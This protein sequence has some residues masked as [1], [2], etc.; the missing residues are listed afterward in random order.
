MED[1]Q[2]YDKSIKRKVLRQKNTS[3]NIDLNFVPETKKSLK[4]SLQVIESCIHL[5]PLSSI[6]ISFNGGKDACVVFYLVYYALWKHEQQ[7]Q[8]TKLSDGNVINKIRVIYFTNDDIFPELADFIRCMIDRYSLSVI[9]YDCSFKEGMQRAVDDG[10]QAVF[11]GVRRGDPYMDEAEHYEPS[12]VGWP[13]FMRINPIIQWKYKQVWEFLRTAD[14]PYCSLYDQGYSSL[15]HASNTVRNPALL[16]MHSND[17]NG[18]DVYLPAYMLVDESL[19]RS[20]RIDVNA[21]VTDN[22]THTNTVQTS[23]PTAATITSPVTVTGMRTVSVSIVIVTD[24]PITHDT[25][26]SQSLSQSQSSIALTQRI[27]KY[28]TTDI[29]L[30]IQLQISI[31]SVLILYEQTQS[32]LPSS[33]VLEHCSHL[34]SITSTSTPSS[35]RTTTT[36]TSGDFDCVLLFTVTPP[37]DIHTDT[38][39]G[40]DGILPNGT[41]T[42]DTTMATAAGSVELREQEVKAEVEE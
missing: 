15:G 3:R 38:I 19:E 23:L 26:G 34:A 13:K 16:V 7:Q 6:A 21:N 9:T 8:S 37:Y 42:T 40:Y 36:T 29:Q 30:Q 1:T 10:I 14:L 35:N 17:G 28:I 27:L 18:G 11:M 41:T 5:Y 22:T 39:I 12:S 31:K 25:D 32:H 24:T 33:R 2:V 4:R 20:C